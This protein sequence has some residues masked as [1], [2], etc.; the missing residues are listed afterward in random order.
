MVW[1]IDLYRSLGPARRVAASI[2]LTSDSVLAYGVPW[3][4]HA[5][6]KTKTTLRLDDDK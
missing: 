2:R 1:L 6:A 3:S 4:D 5:D